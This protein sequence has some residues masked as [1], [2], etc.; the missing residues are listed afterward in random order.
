MLAETF[1]NTPRRVLEQGLR[2]H[3]AAA[4]QAV[5]TP[6]EKT[7]TPYVLRHT[8]AM[9]MLTAGIDVAT[10][11]LWLGREIAASTSADLHADLSI[12]QRALDRSG[13]CQPI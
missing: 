2:I 1:G 11:S 12:K 7:L 6:T 13:R 8:A 5:P 10:I 9:P 3:A 4:A